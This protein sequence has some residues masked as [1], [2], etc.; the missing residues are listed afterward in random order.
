LTFG[1]RGLVLRELLGLFGGEPSLLGGFRIRFGLG[2]RVLLRTRGGKAR[3]LG[4]R[5]L[6]LLGRGDAS[7]LGR[8]LLELELCKA[9]VEAT[10]ILREEGVEGGL[11]ADLQRQLL[12]APRLGLGIWRRFRRRGAGWYQ[13]HIVATERAI[14]E[15]LLAIAGAFQHVVAHESE[16][17]ADVEPG[18]RQVFG[19]RDRERAVVAV[20][21]AVE[22]AFAE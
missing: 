11:V 5:G 22:P 10:G 19:Q 20:A 15:Q 3:P 18:R 7:F 8:D 21:C 6:R 4:L 13:R 9:R 2:L 16:G 1:L 14:D 12:V 17:L